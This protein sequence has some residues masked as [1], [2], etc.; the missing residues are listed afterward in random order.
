MTVKIKSRK[1]KRIPKLRH[2]KASGQGYAVL[3]GK[4]VYFGPYGEEETEQNY[5]RT[6]AE[7]ISGGMQTDALQQEVTIAEVIAR[8]WDHVQ[9]YYVRPDGSSTY[10]QSNIRQAMRPLKELYGYSNAVEFGPRSLI[11]VRKNMIAKGWC[12]TNVNKMVGRI[13]RMFRWS[14]EQEILP[15]SIYQN[16]QTVSGL[17]K[18]RSSARE[19][20]PVKPVPQEHIDAIEPYVSPQIWAMVQ[21][22]Q[23]TGARSG[24]LVI[25][26][27]VDIDTAGKVWVYKPA[28]HKTAHQGKERVVLFGPKAQAILRP[29]LVNR[30]RKDYL[31]SPAEAEENRRKEEFCKRKTRLEWG[32]RPGTNIKLNPQRKPGS[33]YTASSYGH[34]ITKAIKKA[35][36]PKGM[37][38]E[39]F[40]KWK[41]RQH[42]H[43][44]QL[45][46]NAATYLRKEFGLETARIILGHT[47]PVV[48]E[49]YAEM[50]HEKAVEVIGKVG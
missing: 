50:D 30:D 18:G 34:A 10:E 11:A 14:A 39:E 3:G 44:H 15:G 48:T 43:P 45:R 9:E 35:Y 20:E 47:S 16:L 33:H 7:W 24:E 17:K 31:F 21:L 36:R 12:R 2:H 26:R 23:L 5:N 49:I 6:I 28:T 29:W 22:Q 19:S 32:N 41:P 4:A 38:R 46:H 27:P 37:S 1:P 13:K 8:Y 40:K 25:M 42:W